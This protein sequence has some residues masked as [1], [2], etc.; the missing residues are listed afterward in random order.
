[1]PWYDWLACVGAGVL[2]VGTLV[3]LWV[4][5]VFSDNP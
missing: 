4:G 5:W 2:V 3:L 1:M